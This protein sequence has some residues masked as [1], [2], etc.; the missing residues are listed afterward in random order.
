MWLF[1]HSPGE[2]AWKGSWG[3][4]FIHQEKEREGAEVERSGV[5]PT[6][7]ARGVVLQ[8]N[9][10]GTEPFAVGP[11]RH[12]GCWRFKSL[13]YKTEVKNHPCL[14]GGHTAH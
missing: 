7:T 14:S 9:P 3:E 6:A 2:G 13:I 5:D 8:E 12:T 1:P 4:I 10:K 11:R